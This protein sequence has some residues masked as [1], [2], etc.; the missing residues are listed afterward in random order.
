MSPTHPPASPDERRYQKS[1]TSSSFEKAVPLMSGPHAGDD[2]APAT[3]PKLK[4]G[5]AARERSHGCAVIFRQPTV[6]DWRRHELAE[7][8]LD[9][10]TQVNNRHGG[11]CRSRHPTPATHAEERS[12]TSHELVRQ[13]ARLN[14]EET[15]QAA[16]TRGKPRWSQGQPAMPLRVVVTTA[17][18]DTLTSLFTSTE[19]R[20]PREMDRQGVGGQRLAPG[21][22]PIVRRGGRGRGGTPHFDRSSREIGR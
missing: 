16:K 15:G 1:V 4:I 17:L 2:Q 12:N 14:Q 10:S 7:T 13:A 9:A 3:G 6:C 18:I 22:V 5:K 8:K 20:S 11:R 19:G 21:L